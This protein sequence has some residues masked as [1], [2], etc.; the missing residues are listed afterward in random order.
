MN[1]RLLVATDSAVLA[2][3][4]DPGRVDETIGLVG[5]RPTCL[6]ADPHEPG[7]AW[8]GTHH[9][10]VFRSDDR[11]DTWVPVGLADQR[12]MAIAPSPVQPD[13]IW[14][15]TEPSAV[16]RSDDGGG[17]WAPTA[18]LDSLPSSPEWAFPPRPDTHH[19]RWIACHPG[20]PDRLWVAVEAGALISTLDGGATWQ[21]RVHGGPYDTHE[22]DIHPDAPASLRSAAGDGYF[23]SHDGGTIWA[24]PDSGLDV[25][26]LRSVATDPGDPDTVVVSAAS[27]PRSAYVAGRGDGRVYRRGGNGPWARVTDTWP[28]PPSTIAPLLLS[29]RHAGEIWAADERGVH[30]SDDS[31]IHW[32]LVAP[33]EPTPDHLRGLTMVG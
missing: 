12:V 1:V 23:E 8:C 14:V 26:Y 3:D 5:H 11:G 30:H 21:D 22:L 17:E 27:Q 2:V 16:W 19:V 7:R 31:G 4:V 9:G 18:D 20:D 13:L 29:G 6:A 15:G 33:F 10:G 25:G 28:D 24:S 32:R